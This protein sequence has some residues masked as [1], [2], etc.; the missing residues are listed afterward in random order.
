MRLD[1]AVHGTHGFDHLSV[2][3]VDADVTA[4]PDS[5]AGDFG[6]RVN[7]AGLRC[8]VVHLIRA[9]IRHPMRAVLDCLCLRIKPT[10]AFDEPYAVHRPPADPVR[11]NEV[12]VVADCLRVLLQ[13]RGEG[14]LGQNI[15]EGAP[16]G[17]LVT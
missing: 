12:C 3:D 11:A 10:V 2:S 4:L 17:S 7:R 13:L 16:D 6:D 9:D 8:C 14:A 1:H 15:A 5:E